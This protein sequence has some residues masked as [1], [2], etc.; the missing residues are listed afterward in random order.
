MSVANY[1]QLAAHHGHTVGVVIYGGNANATLECETCGE[2]L[3]DFDRHGDGSSPAALAALI[4]LAERHRLEDHDLAGRV[5]DVAE[6]INTQGIAAQLA[7]LLAWQ[8]AEATHEL[9]ETLARSRR[10]R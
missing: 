10:R 3:I 9:I 1:S 7:Y 8:G 4:A 6:S 2:V 5:R